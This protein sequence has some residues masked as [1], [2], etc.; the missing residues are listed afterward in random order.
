MA[1]PQKPENEKRVTSNEQRATSPESQK[2]KPNSLINETSPYLQQHAYNPVRWYPW[3]NESL[4]LAKKTNKPIF[5]SIGYSACHWCHVM[6]HESFEDE[7]TAKVMNEYF[8]NIKVDREER[9]DIDKIYQIAQQLLTQR[10]GGWPLTM[11]LT[12][13]DQI[14]FFAGTY[15][16]PEPRFGLPGFRDLLTQIAEL[17]QTR[18]DD[19]RKQNQAVL[20]ALQKIQQPSEGQHS[21]IDSRQIASALREYKDTFDDQFGGFGGAPKFPQAPN[22]E[23][24]LY[25]SQQLEAEPA[26]ECQKMLNL[27]LMRMATG[28]IYDQLGGGFCR[29]SVDQY[30]LIP[31]FEKMLYDNGQLLFLYSQAW[32]VTKEPIYHDIARET[33]D[34]IM[35]DMQSPE[36]GYYSSLDA[37]SQGQEGKFYVWTPDE[38]DGLLNSAEAKIFNEYFG[39][40]GPPNFD[41]SWHLYI[42]NTIETIAHNHSLS[43][44]DV[45]S[46]ISSAKKKLLQHRNN[47]VW[48]GR[49]D[50]ILSSWNALAIK[51]MA[52]AALRFKDE[53]FLSSALGALEFIHE[54]MWQNGRLCAS[55]KDGSAHLNAYLDD[56]VYLIDAILSILSVKWDDKWLRFALDLVSVII[57]QFYD[58]DH[59]G[60]YFT[61]HDHEKL[62]TRRR[63]YMDDAI[64]SGNGIAVRVL[65]QMAHLSGDHSLLEAAEKTLKSAWRSLE[66]IPHAHASLLHGLVDFLNPH[67]QL[68]LRGDGQNIEHWRLECQAEADI[69]TSIYAIPN[70][71]RDLPGILAECVPK[72][73]VVGYLCE[74]FTCKPPFTELRQ[75]ISGLKQ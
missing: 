2:N 22:L 13:S 7:E 9:P 6:A 20:T 16:P 3:S 28:G 24:L 21:I 53:E 35:R 40:A 1:N 45:R 38:V 67:R 30:W 75:L 70:E 34:W 17:Y 37:D 32:H 39:L 25:A 58:N 49:D 44:E 73:D 74:N 15:F 71:S 26:S 19:I 54:Y 11:I 18:N 68:I 12:P 27:T 55:Y 42:A 4:E 31:H 43:E 51:G 62:L 63:D 33:A 8:I 52:T 60:F 23:F 59:G 41:G 46:A 69:R 29:Y 10:P 14:P 57:E 5:L 64:P 66:E 47:R 65:V 50:K 36:G 48:P 61:S 56:Y 72:H